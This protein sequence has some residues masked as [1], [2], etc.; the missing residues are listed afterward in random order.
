M[1]FSTYFFLLA[2]RLFVFLLA[3]RPALELFLCCCALALP[4]ACDEMVFWDGKGEEKKRR[5]SCK[6]LKL[7]K[8]CLEIKR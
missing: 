7:A 8:V 3:L 1:S 4:L 5:R 6:Y 2:A